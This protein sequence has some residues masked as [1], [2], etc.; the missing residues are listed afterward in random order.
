MYKLI[1]SLLLF[2]IEFIFYSTTFAQDYKD[3]DV[4][5]IQTFKMKGPMG[6]DAEAFREML[7]RQGDIFNKD[8]RVI[9]TYVLRHFW[10]ADSRDLV[11]VTE[12]KNYEDLFSFSNEMESMLEKAFSKEQLEADDALWNKYVG[13]HADEIYQLIPGTKK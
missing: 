8:P 9:S 7:K 12:F 1:L 2:S 3:V 5:L 6:G 13:Q 4:V 10:G 11:I